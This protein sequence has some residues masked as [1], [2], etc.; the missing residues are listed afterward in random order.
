MIGNTVHFIGIGG[1]GMSGIA[2][3]LLEMGYKV[4]GSDLRETKI[5]SKLVQMGA[6]VYLGHREEN[7]TPDVDMVVVSSAIAL[8]N[9]ELLKANRL[10]IPVLH[11]AELLG[12]LMKNKKGIA[13]TGAHGKTTT[14]SL[15][16]TMLEKAGL[17]PTIIVG[18]EIIE[19][20]TNAK[21]GRGD[22]IVLEA[23][24]SDASFLY[25]DPQII[26]VTNIDVDVNLSSS[27]FASFNNDYSSLLEKVK[28]MFKE[29]LFRLPPDG[30][31]ILNIDCPVIQSIIPSISVPYFTFGINNSADFNGTNIVFNEGNTMY[32]FHK[33]GK[34]DRR[35]RTALIGKH[36]VTNSLA[37]IA[38]G[39][40]LGLEWK[41]IFYGLSTFKGVHRR[42]EIIGDVN[43]ILVIDDY[44]HNPAK[45][46]AT[47]Q[48]V[49]E[50][51]SRRRVIAVFQP[52]RYTRVKFLKSQFIN[53]FTFADAIV[54]TPIYSA[55]EKPLFGVTGKELASSIKKNN[56]LKVVYYA[57]GFRE[58]LDWL[59]EN[60][61]S[62]DI[63]ITLGAGDITDI[64]YRFLEELKSGV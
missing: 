44:A 15:I 24:E 40:M 6:K 63:V 37:A 57:E 27:T 52:H 2:K 13:V 49:K 35:V 30:V 19:L 7:V 22:I 61:A 23:D 20:D 59:K 50:M 32:D 21:Y 43:N 31:A 11:R 53:S 58:I 42:L 48:A 34:E 16:A 62:G 55:S 45:I 36:N 9:P 29:F 56:P 54:V 17:S 41:E 33:E 8:D 10:K 1:A 60:T 46:A 47:L 25:L 28:S 39:E 12:L 14:S 5:T 4:T 38:V 3:V 51:W 26:V 64:A 18:G